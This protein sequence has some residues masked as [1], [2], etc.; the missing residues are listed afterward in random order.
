MI[1]GAGKGGKI[2]DILTFNQNLYDIKPDSYFL[3]NVTGDLYG[4]HAEKE[5]WVPKMNVGLHHAKAAQSF[6]SVGKFIIKTPTYKPKARGDHSLTYVSKDI[7]D[8]CS[9]KKLY[10]QHWVLQALPSEF[11]VPAKNNWHIHQ[12]NFVN[13]NKTFIVMAESSRCPEVIYF[14]SFCVGVLFNITRKYPQTLQLL[15]N[16]IST[17]IKEIKSTSKKDLIG[18]ERATIQLKGLQDLSNFQ[19]TPAASS[20]SNLNEKLD[21]LP[22]SKRS[23]QRA[24]SIRILRNSSSNGRPQTAIYHSGLAITHH[25]GPPLLVENNAVRNDLTIKVGGNQNRDEKH[26]S[27][28]S[29]PLF[30]QS[31]YGLSEIKFEY[32][33]T[34]SADKFLRQTQQTQQTR[35]ETANPASHQRSHHILKPKMSQ[36]IEREN[37]FSNYLDNK[38]LLLNR[39]ST[40]G[41]LKNSKLF[42]DKSASEV[43]SASKNKGEVMMLLYPDISRNLVQDAE[44]WV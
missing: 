37:S 1:N 7:E 14:D 8:I 41:I 22:K 28:K 38:S 17:K 16:F 44:A 18:I 31:P 24:S 42:G 40:Q 29:Y 21:K 33:R 10:L 26:A 13:P 39:T 20:N 34:V 9:I 6:D 12:F 30:S 2:G 11:K 19:K 5:E 27:M 32:P 43:E 35:C 15:Y 4:L 36:D 3:D 23:N 25:D